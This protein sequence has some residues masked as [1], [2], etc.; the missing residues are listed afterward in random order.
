[1]L[2]DYSALNRG[3]VEESKKRQ[4]YTVSHWRVRRKKQHGLPIRYLGVDD[5]CHYGALNGG[6]SVEE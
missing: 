5:M 3:G 1:M 2:C 4:I 6:K